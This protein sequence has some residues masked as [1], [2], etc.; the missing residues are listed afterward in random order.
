M[1]TEHGKCL[2]VFCSGDRG[3]C[4][5]WFL[6]GAWHSQVPVWKDMQLRV[7]LC[8]S[9]EDNYTH[10]RQRLL[11][12]QLKQLRIKARVVVT[13]WLPVDTDGRDQVDKAIIFV[14]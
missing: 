10:H 9:P 3:V 2:F 6:I 13:S 4:G 8:A 12:H 1:S 14:T 5:F 11:V 7:F